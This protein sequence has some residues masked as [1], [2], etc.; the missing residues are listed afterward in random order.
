M[1]RSALLLDLYHAARELPTGAFEERA[2][3]MLK[4]L[5]RFESAV[6]GSGVLRQDGGVV[7]NVVHM[8]EQPL[9]SVQEWASI[10]AADPVAVACMSRPGQPIA[11]HAPTLFASPAAAAMRQYAKRYGRQSYMVC[12]LRHEV[13]DDFIVWLSLYR[14]EPDAHFTEAERRLYREVIAHMNEAQQINRRLQCASWGVRDNELCAIADPLG[15]LH[16]PPR[17]IDDLLRLEWSNVR[18]GR[19]PVALLNALAVPGG[20]GIYRGRRV[21]VHIRRAGGLL[22]LR[23]RRCDALDALSAREQEVARAIARGMSAKEAGKVMEV[24]PNTVRVHLKHIYEKLGIH[25]QAELA[26]QVAR[27]ACGVVGPAR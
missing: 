7:P 17:E 12:A 22:F 5:L 3:G 25:S 26:Y 9:E 13:H 18:S 16:T 27:S 4:R 20:N 2:I 1:D 15:Y 21:I 19:L 23:M 24:A 10:N 8:H 14:S 11:F 6:W